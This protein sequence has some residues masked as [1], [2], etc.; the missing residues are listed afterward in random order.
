MFN[1]LDL[2][3]VR[4]K[5]S[6][7]VDSVKNIYYQMDWYEMFVKGVGQRKNDLNWIW[8]IFTAL[9]WSNPWINELID[10]F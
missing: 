5:K 2:L 1:K 6:I 9:V 8:R 10:F 3:K 7:L 4:H